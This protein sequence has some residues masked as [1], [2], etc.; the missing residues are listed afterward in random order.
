ME[1]WDL[2]ATWREM[3]MARPAKLK[4]TQDLKKSANSQLQ[5]PK[6]NMLH[7]G[8]SWLRVIVG[9]VLLST[10]RNASPP[11]AVTSISR[12]ENTACIFFSCVNLATSFIFLCER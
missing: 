6:Q 8:C 10:A 11:A 3:H 5:Q 9:S 7:A 1:S 2:G 4:S 12:K